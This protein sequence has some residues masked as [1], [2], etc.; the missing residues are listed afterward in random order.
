MD[1]ESYYVAGFF[2][3]EG[4]VNIKVLEKK[5]KSGQVCTISELTVEISNND[6]EV[7][8]FI[9]KLC[10]GRITKRYDKNHPHSLRMEASKAVSFLQLVSPYLITK[11]KQASLGVAFQELIGPRGKK[12]TNLKERLK[13]VREIKEDRKMIN[14]L[15]GDK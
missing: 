5:G 3:G 15:G 6:L 13:L 9:H 14:S 1:K 10:G 2:D 12:V 7:L 8:K 4:C 11:K